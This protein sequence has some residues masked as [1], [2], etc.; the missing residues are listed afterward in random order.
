MEQ[1]QEAVRE[2]D[3]EL[4]EYE[5]ELRTEALGPSDGVGRIGDGGGGAG[6]TALQEA[7]ERNIL[8]AL[9]GARAE[10]VGS[11]TRVQIARRMKPRVSP[12]TVTRYIGPLVE[13]DEVIRIT[14]RGPFR[15]ADK[16]RPAE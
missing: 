3:A 9:G 8:K 16:R 14:R 2:Y 10:G 6:K 4:Y 11:L 13:S 15:L 5:H 1:R 7:H 12:R